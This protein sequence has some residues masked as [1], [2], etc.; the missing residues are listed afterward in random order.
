MKVTVSARIGTLSAIA[1]E[2]EPRRRP[3]TTG[4]AEST[5]IPLM[6]VFARA[7]PRICEAPEAKVTFLRSNAL[8]AA[9]VTS[10]IVPFF[11][12]FWNIVNFV[13]VIATMVIVPTSVEIAMFTFN[14]AARMTVMM[15]GENE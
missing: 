8:K 12:T 14:A 2:A 7:L 10:H 13:L 11:R 4:T 3:R 6:F 1:P 5:T 15:I 9:S